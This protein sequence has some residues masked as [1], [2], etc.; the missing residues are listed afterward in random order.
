MKKQFT[1]LKT[2]LLV[3]FMFA[4]FNINAQYKER[5]LRI[6]F[7]ESADA[8]LKSMTIQKSADGIVRTGIESV[9]KM[10]EKYKASKMRRVFPY[11][12]KFEA[13][14]R[15]HGL[16]LWYEIVVKEGVD[17]R[18]AKDDYS[19]ASDVKM[20]ELLYKKSRGIKKA[21]NQNLG[22]L[23]SLPGGTDDPLYSQQWHYNNTGQSG[24]TVDADI[25]LPEAWAIETGSADVIVSL[26][27]GG[28]DID[29]EDL[30]GNIWVN[31]G[32][33]AGNGID[34]DGNGYIDDV[35]GYNFAE[36]TG[37]IDA[38]NH[39]THVAGTIAAETNN[40]IG[41]SGIAGGTGADDGVRLMS[42]EVFGASTSGGFPTSYIYAADNGSV[43]S[44][45]SWGYTSPGA[46]EQAVLDAIDY[47]IA[48]AGYDE[49]GNQ[50]GPMAGGLVIF[51]AGNSGTDNE[52]YPGY[53]EPVMAVAGTDHNDYKYNSSNHGAWVELAAPAVNIYSTVPNDNYTGGYNGTSMA[54][55]HVSGTAAL[56]LSKFKDDGIT[57]GQIWGRLVNS[58]DPLTFDGAEDWGAGRLNA[59]KALAEDDGMPPYAI[60]DMA[61][62]DV[63]AVTVSF[64]WTAPADQPDNYPAI[65]YNFR[66]STTPIT[67]DNFDEAMLYEIPGPQAP[68]TA[69]AIVVSG[70]TPATTYYFA[71]KSS[72]YF[73]NTSEISNTVMATTD[74]APDI[75]V[76]PETI[77]S[78]IDV[79]IDPVKTETLTIHNSGNAELLFDFE[80]AIV[81]QAVHIPAFT[82]EYPMGTTADSKERAPFVSSVTSSSI[83]VSQFAENTAYAH[84]VYPNDYFVSIDTDD[85]TSY[86]TSSSVSYTA[87]AGD[88][89][90]DD[91]E[92]MYIVDNATT[93]LK[94]LNVTTGDLETIG[95]TIGFSDLACDKSSGIMYGVIYDGSSASSLHTV[96]LSTGDA[97]L[98]GEIGPGIMIAIA[99]DGDGNLWGLNLDDNIYSIDKT[100]GHMTLVGAAGFDA[101]Y[102]Q[103]M[104]WDPISDIV[105]LSAYNNGSSAGELRILDTETGATELVGAFPGNAEVTAFGF[106]GAGTPD[107]VTVTPT[108]GTVAPNSSVTVDV[109]LDAAVLP[110]GMHTSSITV[111]SN[112]P[113]SLALDVPVNLDVTGQIGEI[114]ISESMMEFGAVFMNGEKELPLVIHN[115]GIG[116]LEISEISSN[117]AMFTTSLTEPTILELG[118]SLVVMAKFAPTELGQYNGVFTILCNDPNNPEIQITFTG[119]AV[120]P[121]VIALDPTQLEETLDAGEQVVRQF[122]ILNEGLYPLQFSM[123]T[124]AA[125]MLLNNPDIAKNNTSLIEGIQLSDNK[126]DNAGGQGHPIQLGAGG[127]DELG[128]SWIDSREEGGPVFFWEDISETGTE[129]NEDSDDASV[130]VD[131]PFGFKFYGELKT[132]VTVSSNGYLTFGTDGTDYTNDQIPSTT[133]PNNYIA[134]FWDDMRPSSKRGQIFYQS[135]P[136]KFV[137]QFHEM[138]NYPSTTTGTTTFQVVLFPNGDIA[139]YYKEFSLE[140]NESATIGVENEDGTI[141]LQVAYNTDYVADS[142]AVLIFPGRTPFDIG[143]ST[144]AGII[145]P[146]SEVVVDVTIDATDL[147]DGNYINE[148][149]ISSNDPVNPEMIFTTKLDVIGHPEI[150][151][152]PESIEFSSIFQ[153][154]SETR[155]LTIEN[156]GTKDLTVSSIGSDNE[157]FTLDFT[158]P[159]MVATG[160][161][162]A[163]EVTFTAN[164]IGEEN[165]TI[166]IESNDEYAN[167]VV[168]VAVSGTGLV[169]PEISVTTDPDPVELTLNT[170][171]KDTIMVSVAN[172][173]GGSPLDYVLVKPYYTSVGNVAVS[174]G[175]APELLS[176][177]TPDTRVGTPVQAG[178]GGPDA[179]GYTWVDSDEGDE[180]VYDWID[181]SGMGTSYELG[182][183]DLVAVSLPF[184]FPFY[185][186][187]YNELQI[188]SNG[189]ITFD[190]DFTG[191]GYSNQDIP[192][193]TSPNNVVAPLWDDMNP[194]TGGAIYSYATPDYVI[195]QYQDVPKYGSATTATFQAIIYADGSIKYQYQDVDG[196]SG[197]TSATIGVENED[198]TDALPVVFN[199]EYVKDNLAVL[200][201]SPF[202]VGTVEAGTTVNVDLAIDAENIYDGT[203]EAPLKVLSNDPANPEIEIPT[204]LT[205]IGTP[206]ITVSP[207]SL[208]MDTLYYVE[209][210]AYSS[211]KELLISNTGSKVLVIDSIWLSNDLGIFSIEEPSS[212]ELEPEEEMAVAITFTPNAAGS[213]ENV[214]NVTSDAV[215]LSVASATLLG[216]AI[217]PPVLMVE[218]TDTLKLVLLS[219]ETTA[220]TSV[221]TNAGGSLLTYDASI[222]Y[223]PGGFAQ[224]SSEALYTRPEVTTP[225]YRSLAQNG[226]VGQNAAYQAF[227]IDFQDSIYYDPAG[228]PDDY[229]G[230]N[231][232]AGYSSANRFVVTSPSFNLTHVANYYQNNGAAESVIMQIYKGGTGPGEG[233]LIA[234]QE[235]THAEA[236]SGANCL[237]ELDEPI[238]FV[239]GD[240]FFVAFHYPVTINYPA[241]FNSGVSGVD[242]VSYW[243]DINNGVWLDEDNGYVYKI[244][245]YQAEGAVSTDW[246]SIDPV[247]GELEV[248]ASNN[249]SLTVD[250]SATTGGY[251]YAKVVYS[252]N[253]PV[254][255]SVE[256][257]VELYVNYLPEIIFA[258]DTVY[259]DEGQMVETMIVASDSDGGALEFEFA[260]NYEFMEM[261][262]SNDTATIL[263]QPDYE[264]AGIHEIIVN[265]TDDKGETVPVTFAMVVNNVNRTPVLEMDIED[266]LYFP[267]D[268]TATIDLD[269]YFADPDG[270]SLTYEVFAS[271]DTA[272]TVSID[273]AMLEIDP[274]DLGFGVVTITATDP[275]GAY[276]AATFNVRVRHLENHA[277]ILT[278]LIPDQT[279]A[280][281]Q[282]A[283]VDLANYFMDIDWDVIEYSYTISGRPSVF[284]SINGSEL[285]LERY[286]YGMCIVTVYADD[287]R[288]GITAFSFAVFVQGRGRANNLPYQVAPIGDR[289]Y[290][291]S[292]DN[293]RIRLTD[294]FADPDGDA[295]NFVCIVENGDAVDV[296]LEGNDL[297]VAPEALGQSNITI[298]A[299]D[300]RTGVIKTTLMA[301]V[302]EDMLG[303]EVK[304][305]SVSNYPNPFSDITT[306][307][308]QLKEDADVQLEVM[309][310]YGK[311]V[312][313]L[314]DESKNAGIHTIEFNAANLSSGVYFY[315]L[316]VN[317]EQVTRRMVVK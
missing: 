304:A 76:E 116:D 289:F 230:Y 16:H 225:V 45:N 305:L 308:Y 87:Y 172:A 60:T 35:N 73:G 175:T 121:P 194:T 196:Y 1:P 164:N 115:S 265:V 70:L 271:S 250:A 38:D 212:L 266:K 57:P 161:S 130:D 122:T 291:V 17:V 98:I 277:P 233:D 131:L 281:D 86:L 274:F 207:D 251:Y 311:T 7:T 294:F 257:P 204:T 171:D 120:S 141:G 44:Q 235:F 163:V 213:F 9:D 169:P 64:T 138:G 34:D 154:L 218:P 203:Y 210:E 128:Y 159:L 95:A 223:L 144:V 315:R 186:R 97:T 80:N 148:L 261:T 91:M 183:D 112:D 314:V 147:I 104:A 292:Q 221:V 316:T 84:E 208:L 295:L 260:A 317:D 2:F 229:Y 132:S 303:T 142:L 139:Y 287:Q 12:G 279:V 26:H 312:K 297:V 232:S 189:F 270:Q 63:S 236:T 195:V 166:T 209:G 187:V 246:L 310:V 25:D 124:V 109:Q 23:G 99:C 22:L 299:S 273:G 256:W 46:Y 8:K 205:V 101:N 93:E 32:E 49:N 193:T 105:Y 185:N 296:K 298:Y 202:V 113:G 133:E 146:N 52:W 125:S 248:G 69:E 262:V 135:Y 149:L 252:S 285:T 54:C 81:E 214:I 284:A 174:Q 300:D 36:N 272:F 152:S 39:G 253:D 188:C 11:A 282:P 126:E 280:P 29:H 228:T 275:E 162:T 239:E 72:D 68:G 155:M 111:Y 14:H 178:N 83:P 67:A 28:I 242:G 244:R 89:G 103:S 127:P 179:F 94:L 215:N 249:H 237:I 18:L 156:T 313:L 118:D 238:S 19:K 51:A 136:D 307:E 50:V 137:V 33:I 255:P 258:K 276:A 102:A 134:P 170:G 290:Q 37:V 157:S 108:S 59:F 191:S 181:I 140:N 71:V 150:V 220:E 30:A 61:I 278:Q 10:N 241:A 224:T 75:S 176:K 119:I 206:E 55:P 107:F 301:N 78:S 173:A 21:S 240:V 306:I 283:V 201:K 145:Q 192:T 3:V 58:T 264:Q 82:G 226:K 106:P 165:G 184:S 27:D 217:E 227:D 267:T 153:T 129:I 100:D 43:I 254:T 160:T 259:V 123:P 96:D 90:K 47:F 219:T 20:S 79:S 4:A 151:V 216:E 302:T 41:M 24:G 211:T 168:T 65:Y 5:V 167:E 6:K 117:V 177:E 66:Y 182:D 197:T 198:G 56:I 13:K 143:V 48:E 293:D 180:V 263:Y 286:Q 247:E 269:A 288:G 234:S 53:Y 74:E 158:A 222:V 62:S 31:P 200:I 245:A 231:G 114:S 77:N 85:P 92:H 268:P 243:F 40:G 199:S 190:M 309:N 42:C 15:K 88:F 110:N